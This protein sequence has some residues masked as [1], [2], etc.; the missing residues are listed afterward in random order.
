MCGEVSLSLASTKNIIVTHILN[1]HG[2]ATALLWFSEYLQ[3][4]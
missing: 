3:R 2:G 1:N 4:N